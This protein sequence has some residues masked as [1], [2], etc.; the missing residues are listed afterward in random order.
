MPGTEPDSGSAAFMVAVSLLLILAFVSLAIDASFGYDERR[1]LQN[2][3]DNAAYA[4]AYESCSPRTAGAPD[5]EAAAR[6]VAD[7]NGFAHDGLATIV[8]AQELQPDEWTVTISQID[9][10]TQFGRATP[11]ANDV[12]TIR[13]EGTATCEFQPFLGGY[14]VFAGAVGCPPDE[15][16]ISGSDIVI[17]GAVHT[18][19]DV[20]LTGSSPVIN[21]DITYVPPGG[22]HLSGSNTASPTTTQDYP[23]DPELFLEY[24]PGGARA[25]GADYHDFTGD[26]DVRNADLIAASLGTGNNTSLEIT[27]SGIFYAPDDMTLK[28]VSLAPGVTITLIAEGTIDIVANGD[29]EGYDPVDPSNPNSTRLTAFSWNVDPTTCAPGPASAVSVSASSFSWEG[30]I[31]APNGLVSFSTSAASSF[32]GSIIAYTINLSGSELAVAYDDSAN[33][34]PTFTLDLLR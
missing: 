7:R 6:D 1:D 31:F 10:E 9:N 25:L 12:F 17:D 33:A 18:N 29:I 26:T 16:N 13:A 5:P 19:Q 14:A 23:L 22:A 28:G 24:R 21:G 30:L 32:S 11:Y 2:A 15:L 3:A 27:Q 8:T 34:D 4:A 20:S